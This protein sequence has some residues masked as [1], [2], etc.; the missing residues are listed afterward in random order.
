[1]LLK[2]L[3]LVFVSGTCAKLMFAT[4]AP[5]PGQD[6]EAI[7]GEVVVT[8]KNANEL[9]LS[10]DL[11]GVSGASGG[12]H[13]HAGTDCNTAEGPGGHF[14]KDQSTVD[15]WSTKWNATTGS[16]SVDCGYNKTEVLGRTI[17]AH[18]EA[19]T[20]V[21]CGVLRIPAVKDNVALLGNFF[22]DTTSP[23]A[24]GY[25]WTGAG[26]GTST[27]TYDISGAGILANKT[28]GLHIHNGRSCKDQASS[29]DHYWKPATD[30]DPWVT[31]W[32]A[33]R[34]F[35]IARGSFNVTMGITDNAAVGHVVVA[36]APNGTRIA[37]G[38][39][40]GSA[41][42]TTYPAYTGDVAVEGFAYV[43][44]DTSGVPKISWR[45]S[46]LD[47]IGQ[48]HIHEAKDCS[49]ESNPHFWN[50]SMSDP[51]NEE[52]CPVTVNSEGVSIGS[53]NLDFGYPIK[54]AL[55][56]T[57]IVHGADGTKVACGKISGDFVALP[58]ND[59]TVAPTPQSSSA[60]SLTPFAILAF[61]GIF[62]VC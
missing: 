42:M 34:D 61:L 55:G 45:F 48:V 30:E 43:Y 29:G 18:N 11:K 24:S 46:G 28:G 32:Q 51:W 19:G 17:V 14:W 33:E 39:I 16:F 4:L 2:S 7:G 47:G 52:N 31:E 21:L 36:H 38:M 58:T 44:E 9:T 50:K 40:A 59:S 12:L 26:A 8:T 54:N 53:F 41:E 62:L 10:Y 60:Y 1:M 49:A 56:R 37:C 20:R 6:I 3:L 13:I 57:F 15:P 35:T 22:D 5:Y 27:I 25:V 23:K